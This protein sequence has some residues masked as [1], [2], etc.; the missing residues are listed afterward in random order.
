MVP[1]DDDPSVEL[2]FDRAS[3]ALSVTDTRDSLLHSNQR[4]ANSSDGRDGD[5]VDISVIT[6]P[7]DRDWTRTYIERIVGGDDDEFTSVKQ[8]VR[9]DGTEFSGSVTIRPLRPAMDCVGIVGVVV[10]FRTR[11][12]SSTIHGSASCSNTAPARSP[13]PMPPAT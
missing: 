11:E 10:P 4:S 2:A 13:W 7:E 3:V 8:F 9:R 12:N 6:R 1:N 5:G